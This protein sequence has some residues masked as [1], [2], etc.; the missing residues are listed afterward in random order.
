M[1]TVILYI[2]GFGIGR[3]DLCCMRPDCFIA[4]DLSATY[5]FELMTNEAGLEMAVIFLQDSLY[6]F[7]YDLIPLSSQNYFF[8]D[9]FNLSITTHFP[10]LMDSA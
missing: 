7:P 3:I 8:L 10:H 6:S 9:Y 5:L 2:V 4:A 1:V